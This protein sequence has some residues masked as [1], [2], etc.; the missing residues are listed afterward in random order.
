MVPVGTTVGVLAMVAV[1]VGPAVLA[2]AAGQICVAAAVLAGVAV[3][4]ACV[5]TSQCGCCPPSGSHAIGV[6]LAA[7][8]DMLRSALGQNSPAL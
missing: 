6:P 4:V 2:R 8:P 5:Q 7:T 1:P 3:A